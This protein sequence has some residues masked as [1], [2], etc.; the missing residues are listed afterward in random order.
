MLIQQGIYQ[1]HQ[2]KILCEHYDYKPAHGEICLFK[3]NHHSTIYRP[4]KVLLNA[5]WHLAFP[6]ILKQ[7]GIS[8]AYPSRPKAISS[9]YTDGTRKKEELMF[10]KIIISDLQAVDPIIFH[11]NRKWWLMFTDKTKSNYSLHLWYA[12]DFRG[13]YFPAHQQ[14]SKN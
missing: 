11:H 7:K 4:E 6:F 13:P 10:E 1:N 2:L 14:S 9:G 8:G 12:E 5:S 3:T